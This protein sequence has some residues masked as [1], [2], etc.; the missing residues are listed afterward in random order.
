MSTSP[1]KEPRNRAR[2]AGRHAAQ[3][4]DG[5][6][7]LRGH[8]TL[9]SVTRCKPS[10]ERSQTAPSFPELLVHR[11]NISGSGFASF[12]RNVNG[13]ELMGFGGATSLFAWGGRDSSAWC[14]G[15]TNTCGYAHDWERGKG[16]RQTTVSSFWIRGQASWRLVGFIFHAG[17]VLTGLSKLEL[18]SVWFF[19][20][21]TCVN[22]QQAA[23]SDVYSEIFLRKP[24]RVVLITTPFL[25]PLTNLV[26]CLW[27][28]Q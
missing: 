19:L 28:K 24:S 23:P 27:E 6:R 11:E 12:V 3:F 15:S 2:N 25:L 17:F 21:K 8:S 18:M 14:G 13:S 22:T 9:Y 4:T 5:W 7:R 1:T 20:N 26:V 10:N 16:E